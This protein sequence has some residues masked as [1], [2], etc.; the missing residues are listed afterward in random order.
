MKKRNG[1]TLVELLVVI[2]IIGVL[3][4]LLLPA[5]QQAREAARRMQCTNG[6]KQ[7]VLALHNYES[8]FGVYPSGRLGC[9]GACAP[10][11]G[12]GTSGFVLLLPFL[13]QGNLYDQF[14][15]YGPGSAFPGNLSETI[16]NTR[17]EMYV[18]PSS[19]MKASFNTGGK[20]WA[21]ASYA[22]VSGHYGASQGIGSKVKW[23]NTGMFV[24]RDAYGNRD[25]LDGLSNVMYIGE[26]IDG[27]LSNHS[28]R[29]TI[30][31]RLLDCLRAT[32]NPINT[33]PGQ[34]ITTSPYG[35]ALN[36][37]FGSRH[38]G[39]ANFGY[40]DGSVHFVAETINLN[41]YKLLGQ[42]ASGL[43]KAVN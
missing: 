38:P 22:F 1:F 37:A 12:P 25:A 42:R 43:P 36:A 16:L 41:I 19:V 8:T 7:I 32:E 2:A 34:G 27:H 15:P 28:N 30:A 31:A 6:Q 39:G 3:I 13:E 26:V 23:E 10:A 9:D 20:N 21:T 35:E 14:A 40:G 4:A 17:P 18:C 29:W 11:N 5:V 24:Y 33:P